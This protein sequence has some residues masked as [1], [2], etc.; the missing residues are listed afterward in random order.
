MNY[1]VETTKS[2]AQVSADL[3]AAV[4]KNGF[5]V[6]HIHDLQKTLKGKGID[7]VNGCMVFEVCNPQIAARVLGYD[8]RLNMALPCRISVWQDD[9]K[10]F[11]GMVAPQAI[12]ALISQDDEL[13]ATADEVASK[14]KSIIDEAA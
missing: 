14:L 12:L 4:K 2:M 13:L 10:I 8:M 6:L 1:I 9:A 3:E 5:G 7:F 11:I